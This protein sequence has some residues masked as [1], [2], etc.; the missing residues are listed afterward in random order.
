MAK[1]R[2]YTSFKAVDDQGITYIIDEFVDILDVGSF[3]D[4]GAE[5]EGLKDLI[6]KDGRSVN[7]VK[8]GEYKIV[9]EESKILRSNDP[10]AP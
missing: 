10:E 9:G 2:R 5:I 1:E 4:P 6:T 3:N 7:R 8:K